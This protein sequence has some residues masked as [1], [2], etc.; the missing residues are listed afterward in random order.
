MK[1]IDR[2]IREVLGPRKGRNFLY[3]RATST[4]PPN[5]AV[6]VAP[7]GQPG[8]AVD[9]TGAWLWGVSAWGGTDE[10]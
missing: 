8:G 3:V 5:I 6:S 4:L 10:F 7:G 1:I 9:V 2:A